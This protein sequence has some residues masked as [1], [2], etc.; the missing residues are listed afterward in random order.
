M[1]LRCSWQREVP[2]GATSRV[3]RRPKP[4]AVRLDDRAA[5]RQPHPR[6]P[7]LGR[8]ERVEDLLHPV[9]GYS[10]TCVTHRRHPLAVL[11]SCA[12]REVASPLGHGSFAASRDIGRKYPRGFLGIVPVTPYDLAAAGHE[13]AGLADRNLGSV[14]K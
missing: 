12:D 6:P 5:D 9:S 4:A 2:R 13:L 8:E 3:H 1:R 7:G 11:A 10:H 14:R